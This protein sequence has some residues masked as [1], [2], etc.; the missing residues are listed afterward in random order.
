MSACETLADVTVDAEYAAIGS[1]AGIQ[2]AVAM[3]ERQVM[4][5]AERCLLL[6]PCPF[7]CPGFGTRV[8]FPAS[9]QIC[10]QHCCTMRRDKNRLNLNEFNGPGG[11]G[12]RE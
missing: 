8:G 3:S 11:M 10:G 12:R 9:R 2:K 7:G 4:G 5:Y 6:V 1:K